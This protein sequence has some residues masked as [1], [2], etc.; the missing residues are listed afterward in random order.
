MTHL[1][2]VAFALTVSLTALVLSACGTM[3]KSSGQSE[4][5]LYPARPQHYPVHGVDISHHQGPVDWVAARANGTQ[6]AFLK[7]TEGGDYADDTFMAHWIAT[8]DAGVKRGAYHFYYWCRNV[9]DQISWFIRNVPVE[10]DALPPVLDVEWNGDSKTCSKKVPRA[11]ALAAMKRFLRAVEAHYHKRPII[12]TSIDF[13][14]EI[15]D[16]DLIEYPLWVR[17][18]RAHPVARYANR[19]WTFWQYTET[20]DVGGIKGGVDRNAFV[21]TEEEWQRFINHQ[22]I[23]ASNTSA[24]PVNQQLAAAMPPAQGPAG[25]GPANPVMIANA[26]P[27]ASTL[28]AMSADATPQMSALAQPSAP[29][30]QTFAPPTVIASSAPVSASQTML[31]FTKFNGPVPLPPVRR[32]VLAQN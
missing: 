18:V 6:F 17:T 25:Q 15:I 10:A 2:A 14:R 3:P 20:G 12:Y 19:P 8:R 4:A 16:G 7:A 1:R 30:T 27:T 29:V 31:S 24:L 9:E 28:E 5:E 11:E 22:V 13:Y 32:K 26:E 23:V 21:G